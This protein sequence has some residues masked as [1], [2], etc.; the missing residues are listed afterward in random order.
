MALDQAKLADVLLGLAQ[1][2]SSGA[3]LAVRLTGL[4][5][6]ATEITGCRRSRIFLLAGEFY[7]LRYTSGEIPDAPRREH[8]VPAQDRL[9][10]EAVRTRDCVV[11]N[12]QDSRL[13]DA[14]AGLYRRSVAGRGATVGRGAAGVRCPHRR[15]PRHSG[16]LQC[17]H[18]AAAARNGQ[19]CWHGGAGGAAARSASAARSSSRRRLIPPSPRLPAN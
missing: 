16:C 1:H 10:A 11:A 18:G 9:I 12:P 3:E 8:K 6:A 4:C 17:G 13:F 14:P 5:R 15:I 19:A 2:L 7:E